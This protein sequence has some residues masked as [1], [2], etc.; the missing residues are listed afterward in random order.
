MLYLSLV[1]VALQRAGVELAVP[2][3]EDKGHGW[4]PRIHRLMLSKLVPDV[5]R[6]NNRTRT[7]SPASA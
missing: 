2:V 6:S 1:T 5:G 3:Q 4:I 7:E